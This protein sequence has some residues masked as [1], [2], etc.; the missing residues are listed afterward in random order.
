M[1][2]HTLSCAPALIDCTLQNATA[3]V[4]LMRPAVH[5]ALDAASIAALTQTFVRMPEAV[6]IVVLRGSGKSFCAGAD[7]TD[8]RNS[9]HHAPAQNRAD[10]EALSAL[11]AAVASAPQVVIAQVH[12]AALGG[13]AGL[14]CC[15]DLVVAAPDARFGF[16]EARLG[17]APAVIAPHVVR[18]IGLAKAKRL[19]LTADLLDAEAAL[20]VGLVDTVAASH[21]PEALSNVVQGWQTSILRNGPKAISRIKSLLRDI[22]QLD[23]AAAASMCIDTISQ[24]RIGAEAQAGLEAFLQKKTPPWAE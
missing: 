3:F 2:K 23:A 6:R 14:V 24:M 17:L 10:A 22:T 19:F 11:F 1:S 21:A 20:A 12:G 7:L 13:G 15:C 5:N 18:R 4:T 16:T 9:V 8:M